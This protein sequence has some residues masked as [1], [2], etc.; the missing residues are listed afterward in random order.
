MYDLAKCSAT[1]AT[2]SASMDAG[3]ESLT[4]W[5]AFGLSRL[6]VTLREPTLR[7]ERGERG[8]ETESSDMLV[9]CVGA[10]SPGSGDCYEEELVG[11][12]RSPNLRGGRELGPRASRWR[13]CGP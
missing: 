10:A 11:G 12:A 5:L 9:G 7:G 8:G 1:R 2:G 6:I 4:V 13:L 3:K